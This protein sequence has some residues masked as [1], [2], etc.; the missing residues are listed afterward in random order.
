MM[1]RLAVIAGAIGL[2]AGCASSSTTYGPDGRAAHAIQCSGAALSWGDC[3]KKAGEIC[4]SAGYDLITR[5]GEQ[6]GTAGIGAFGGFAGSTFYRS[7]LVS[8]RGGAR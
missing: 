6:G 4:Q 3:Y 5:S 7:M 8:C 1:L 2:V